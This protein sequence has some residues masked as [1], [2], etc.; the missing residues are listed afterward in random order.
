MVFVSDRDAATQD[1][2]IVFFRKPLEGGGSISE[3]IRGM[4][5]FGDRETELEQH[6]G[7][8][9]AVGIVELA[10]QEG[11]CARGDEFVASA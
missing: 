6:C 4:S 9:G 5:Q 2:D 10:G 1:D 7:D 11:G 3:C 8:H